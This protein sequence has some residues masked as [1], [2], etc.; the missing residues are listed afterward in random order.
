MYNM[1]PTALLP[2][3]KKERWGFFRPKNPKASTGFEPANSV[4]KVQHAHLKTT[5]AA[6]IIIGNAYYF[7]SWNWTQIWF[8][9]ATIF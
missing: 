2:L 3:R 7:V 5:E 8:I 6:E 4:T 9:P 1:G